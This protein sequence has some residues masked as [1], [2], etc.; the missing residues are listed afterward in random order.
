MPKTNNIFV[1]DLVDN[2]LYELLKEGGRNSQ[3]FIDNTYSISN[4]SFHRPHL[5]KSMETKHFRTFDVHFSRQNLHSS[6]LKEQDF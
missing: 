6:F 3:I 5:V 1:C 4:N 2:A